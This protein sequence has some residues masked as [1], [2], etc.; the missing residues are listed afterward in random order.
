MPVHTYLFEPGRWRA[1]G[2]FIDGAGARTEAEGETEIRHEEERWVVTTVMRGASGGSKTRFDVEPHD[3][4]SP[5]LEWASASPTM[6]PVTGTFAVVDDAI[7]SMYRSRD[8]GYRGSET[9]RHLPDG[10]YDCTGVLLRGRKLLSAWR[11]RLAR[12]ADP[13]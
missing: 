2:Q 3:G 13:D 1:A 11:V 6:G 12:V 7:V 8:G 10:G 4:T 5:V 9:Y